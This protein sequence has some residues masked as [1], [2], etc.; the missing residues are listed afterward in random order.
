M[1]D[2]LLFRRMITP[3][4]FQVLFWVALTLVV[5]S[6]VVLIATGQPG[7]GLIWLIVGPVVLRIFSEVLILF[8]RIHDSLAAIRELLQSSA[9]HDG[10]GAGAAVP[11][12]GALLGGSGATGSIRPSPPSASQSAPAAPGLYQ[13]GSPP[14]PVGSMPGSGGTVPT[15]T[16]RPV[17][18]ASGPPAGQATASS[19]MPPPP[20]AGPD[21]ILGQVME[22]IGDGEVSAALQRWGRHPRDLETD[23]ALKTALNSR[24]A[25][26]PGAHQE[27]L[28]RL[29]SLLR[30]E[31]ERLHL[32]FQQHLPR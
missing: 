16:S 26:L 13:T 10:A 29:L 24:M 30:H 5:V 25:S 12:L 32:A 31:P 21:R 14:V 2:F 18:R 6:G 28:I 27:L 4:I 23:S 15:T 19:L 1:K 3:V 7:P 11:P 8:F 20:Q 22:E 9:G 17:E